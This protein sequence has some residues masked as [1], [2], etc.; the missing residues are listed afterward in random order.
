MKIAGRTKDV[1]IRGGENIPVAYVENVLY[2]H[3]DIDAVAV[4]AIPHPRLQEIA[5]AAVTLRAGSPEFSFAAM[6]AFLQEKGVAKPYWPERLEVV[7]DFPRTPSGKI[8]NSSCASA[9]PPP[10]SPPN[11]RRTHHDNRR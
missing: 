5:C 8:Q 9:S 1:I 7:S 11:P 10:N 4:V 2:E 6:Q 3:P